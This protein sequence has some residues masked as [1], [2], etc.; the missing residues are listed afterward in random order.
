LTREAGDLALFVF[1]ESSAERFQ[2]RRIIKGDGVENTIFAGIIRRFFVNLSASV[3]FW[4]NRWDC[5]VNYV[6]LNIEG[7]GIFFIGFFDNALL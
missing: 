2:L 1:F 3:V 7:F 4:L 6:I 5:G